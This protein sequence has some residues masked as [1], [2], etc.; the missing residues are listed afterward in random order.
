MEGLERAC[1]PLKAKGITSSCQVMQGDP[2]SS[3]Q[4]LLDFHNCDTIVVGRRKV[5]KRTFGSPPT[6]W[7]IPTRI[8][9]PFASAALHSP[10][11]LTNFNPLYSPSQ[12]AALFY[13]T[14]LQNRISNLKNLHCFLH[15]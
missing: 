5:A 11:S 8:L 2:K 9:S 12:L 15:K 4:A 13:T 6:S 1:E 3:V 10:I 14:Y 7:S